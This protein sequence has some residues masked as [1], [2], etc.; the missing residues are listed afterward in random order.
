MSKKDQTC[1]Y[2]MKTVL[3]GLWDLRN[4]VKQNKTTWVNQDQDTMFTKLQETQ[5]DDDEDTETDKDEEDE[6]FRQLNEEDYEGIVFVQDD[7]LCN[8]QH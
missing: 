4:I 7:V 3:W 8:M 1:S 2:L 6:L 5:N